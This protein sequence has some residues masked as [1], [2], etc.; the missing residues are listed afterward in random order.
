MTRDGTISLS[1]YAVVQMT[2]RSRT[3][4]SVLLTCPS[5]LDSGLQISRIST[6]EVDA[7]HTRLPDVPC[8]HP[9]ARLEESPGSQVWRGVTCAT[10]PRA[11]STSC[12]RCLASLGATSYVKRATIVR[13]EV[14][15]WCAQQLEQVMISAYD[16]AAALLPPVGRLRAQRDRLAKELQEVHRQLNESQTEVR[17]QISE[18]QKLAADLDEMK[19]WVR[20]PRLYPPGHFYSPEPDLDDVRR[21][22]D[23]IFVAPE[24]IVG[25][26]LRLGDQLALLDQISVAWSDWPYQAS[27]TP[28]LRFNPRNDYFGYVDSLVLYSLLRILMPKRYVEVGSGWSSALVLDTRDHYLTELETTF[29]EPHPDRLRSLLRPDDAEQARII[30][31]PV[32]RVE[33]SVFEQLDPGDILFIDSTHVS[34]V[35][36]DVNHLFFNVLPRVA[37]GVWI[38]V[39]DIGY[40]F[41]YP[42][43]WVYEGRS[44]NEAYLLR[45]LLTDS[46][47]WEI[48]LWV[49]CLQRLHSDRLSRALP[50]GTPFD[51][52]SIWLRRT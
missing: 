34:K 3:D 24:H 33:V 45:A 20:T 50:P 30:A 19:P 13:C 4:Q 47:I 39:H 7:W 16:V 38:H 1:L 42:K 27:A 40:P 35:G 46:P 2:R 21:R 29:I 15:R 51:G 25:V 11:L 6:L 37:P 28:G 36:S 8:H 43:E 49:S 52:G 48:E 17:R 9:D 12:Q 23:T 10:L 44:W 18:R 14:P 26:D 31:Q 22:A 32:Q 41:E 5:K